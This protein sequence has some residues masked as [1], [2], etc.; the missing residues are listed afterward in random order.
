[1]LL[2]VVWIF[3]YALAFASGF[4]QS[5]LLVLACVFLGVDFVRSQLT[6]DRSD[7]LDPARPAA[8][9]HRARQ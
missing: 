7:R 5:A 3:D 9:N 2:L 4:V 8:G 1:M 6:H